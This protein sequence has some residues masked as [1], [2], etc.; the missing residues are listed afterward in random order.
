MRQGSLDLSS[1][2]AVPH[3][4]GGLESRRRLPSGPASNEGCDGARFGKLP[5]QAFAR[6]AR[7]GKSKPAPLKTKGAA[8]GGSPRFHAPSRYLITSLP[9][10]VASDP[11][12]GTFIRS[13]GRP[14]GRGGWLATRANSRRGRLLARVRRWR[15]GASRDRGRSVR[16]AG[17]AL[18]ALGPGTRARP[19]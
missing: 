7:R 4:S 2:R 19:R 1:T 15:G 14:L 6:S 9:H 3:P 10:C 8:P 5:L 11:L 13:A 12:G 18:R 17:F 16:T